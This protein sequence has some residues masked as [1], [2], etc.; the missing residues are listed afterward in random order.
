MTARREPLRRVIARRGALAAAILVVAVAC[1][2]V[3]AGAPD[4]RQD[5]RD[6]RSIRVA[7]VPS[8][9][10]PRIG[11]T[12]EWRL[13]ESNARNV[14]ARGKPGA[15]W[16]VV[17]RAG[18]VRAVR[19][20][21]TP[22]AWREGPL[23]LRSMH[24]DEFISVEGKTYRGELWI[25][26]RRGDSVQVI[27]VLPVEQYLRG[28]VPLEIGTT[29]DLSEF[30]A[31]QAQAVAARTY[32]YA[33]LPL[34]TKRPYD[35]AATVDDQVYGGVMAERPLSDRAVLETRGLVLEYGGRLA[36]AP[37]S[38][39]C[40][41]HTAAQPEVWTHRGEQPYLRS[42]SD[43][44][45]GTDRFYCD[46]S[47]RFNWKRTYNADE[48]NASLK[49]YLRGYAKVASGGPGNARLI[50][51]DRLTA[52]GR[53]GTL[54]IVTDRDR[55]QLKGNAIRFV[56]RSSGG[57]ILN[58]TYFSVESDVGRNGRLS[59]VHFTGR[60]NG[61]GIGMCQW[62][63]IGRARAGQDFRQILR[64]YYQGTTIA[65]IED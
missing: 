64:T 22:T 31:V 41:G 1:A 61:H 5:A 63:A 28:V 57:E 65:A 19:P 54:T 14:V 60:G 30:A 59:R 47:P 4:R 34:T 52:S 32:T 49:R 23:V 21:G 33:K 15:A 43:R 6:G 44:I 10:A 16:T 58:S 55:Y 35:L 2:A 51:V 8:K 45:P 3:S 12:G 20:D 27:N 62:G 40:G 9:K 37:Y 53:V 7:V 42:I 18:R 17:S 46:I 38:S 29:R 11:G 24:P 39:T 56:L 36:Q 26:G 50:A 25:T 48:L 13:L